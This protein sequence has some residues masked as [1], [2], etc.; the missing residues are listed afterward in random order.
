MPPNIRRGLALWDGL[1]HHQ[2]HGGVLSLTTDLAALA[3][4]G[5]VPNTGPTFESGFLR[6]FA[7]YMNRSAEIGWLLLRLVPYLQVAKNSFGDEWHA[8]KAILDESFRFM[9][10]LLGTLGKSIGDALIVL[11]DEKFAFRPP[12]HYREADGMA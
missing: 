10:E 3:R 9:L 11:V 4:R 1:F 6:S 5:E 2:V 7:I 12:F 8:K